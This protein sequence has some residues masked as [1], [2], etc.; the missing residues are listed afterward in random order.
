MYEVVVL[1]YKREFSLPEEVAQFVCDSVMPLHAHP[2]TW[3]YMTWPASTYDSVPKI[4]KFQSVTG[5]EL[6]K[7]SVP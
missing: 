1:E 4:L 3:Y 2:K 5:L 6:S 7:Q